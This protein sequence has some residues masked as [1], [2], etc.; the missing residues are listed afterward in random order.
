[1]KILKLSK[2]GQRLVKLYEIMANEGLKRIDGQLIQKPYNEFQ[3]SKFR[4]LI[5]TDFQTYDIKTVL[6]YGSG[7]SDWEERGFDPKSG[8]SAKDYFSLDKIF[9]YEPARNIDQRIESECVVCIDVLEHIFISDVP[10]VLRDIFSCANKLIVINVS[11]NK[12]AALLPNGEN[13]HITIRPP[14]WWKGVV[15]IIS[16]E[17]PEITVRLIC[18]PKMKTH[19][20]FDSWSVDDWENDANFKIDLPEAKTIGV[21]PQQQLDTNLLFDKTKSQIGLRP[22]AKAV[23]DGFLAHMNSQ[24]N[25]R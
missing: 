22:E 10:N 9:K 6:D 12:A 4:K 2:K 24:K 18:S 25:K 5:L 15:D 11:T 8:K 7:G 17:F 1:M 23:S 16:T 20:V 13:A 14:A 21:G 19:L 3:L